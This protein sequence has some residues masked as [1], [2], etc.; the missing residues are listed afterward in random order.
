MS[1]PLIL[2]KGFCDHD[3][4]LMMKTESRGRNRIR[5]LA[6]HHLQRGKSLKYVS[7]IVGVHWKTV[8]AW[9]RRFRESGFAGLL[10]SA[11][12]GAPKKITG[13]AESWLA[14]KIRTLSEAKTGGHIT[15]EELREL[16]LQEHG[17]SCTLK[18]IY[19]KLHQLNFSW[20]TSRSIHPKASIKAQEDYKKTFKTC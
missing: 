15:G 8:Q 16:L 11:R 19:N 20:I 13:K 17:V 7:E 14:E 5:L 6:M 3:F 4:V 18:T 9:L 1:R 2:P 10:E 12:C